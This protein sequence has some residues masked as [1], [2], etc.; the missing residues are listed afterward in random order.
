[1]CKMASTTCVMLYPIQNKSAKNGRCHNKLI[2]LARETTGSSRR[3]RAGTLDTSF[4]KCKPFLHSREIYHARGIRLFVTPNK[5]H[6]RTKMQMLKCLVTSY[7]R[8]TPTQLFESVLMVR[9]YSS[10]FRRT[11]R[12]QLGKVLDCLSSPPTL[13]QH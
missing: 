13:H 7:F 12:K 1:M 4:E 8:G 3:F 2:K 5:Y 10:Y 6:E 9:I 11:L